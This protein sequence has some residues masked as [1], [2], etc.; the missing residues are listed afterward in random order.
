MDEIE[1]EL[2]E[3]KLGLEI[4]TSPMV[5]WIALDG[6]KIVDYVK[7]RNYYFTDGEVD[8]VKLNLMAKQTSK[9]LEITTSPMVKWIY[10]SHEILDTNQFVSKL[11]LHRW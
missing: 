2:A 11:L 10:E 5:K 1:V 3:Y 8:L 4:T 9:C 7:S 6:G